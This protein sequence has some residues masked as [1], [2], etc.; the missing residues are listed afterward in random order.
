MHSIK[1][2]NGN[3]D[4]SKWQKI[5]FSF[6]SVPLARMQQLETSKNY[7]HRVSPFQKY[8]FFWYQCPEVT[9]KSLANHR[10]F[11]S[12][13]SITRVL[14]HPLL[15]RPK[16]QLVQHHY[17]WARAMCRLTLSLTC[18]FTIFFFFSLSTFSSYH[19]IAMSV[20]NIK[21]NSH[22]II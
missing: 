15:P 22:A 6:L 21:N 12:D 3:I 11:V 16:E 8:K 19:T 5:T 7:K 20:A 17:L 10:R 2:L 18:Y 14:S 1:T 4:K 9:A 13:V